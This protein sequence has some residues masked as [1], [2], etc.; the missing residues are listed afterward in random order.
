MTRSGAV[1]S[2]EYS[3]WTLA[4][5]GPTAAAAPEC[6][7]ACAEGRPPVKSS[8]KINHTFPDDCRIGEVL[9]PPRRHRK[10]HRDGEVSATYPIFCCLKASSHRSDKPEGHGRDD[11]RFPQQQAWDGTY[12]SRVML[13]D[14]SHLTVLLDYTDTAARKKTGGYS[15]I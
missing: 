3:G 14:G 9:C 10:K 5:Q 12:S 6:T 7:Q 15:C 11:L 1:N 2:T 4:V 13:A 8:P